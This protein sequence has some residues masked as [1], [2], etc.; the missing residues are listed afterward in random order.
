MVVPGEG[1]FGSRIGFGRDTEAL[2]GVLADYAPY[3][4]NTERL[5]DKLAALKPQRLAIMHGSSFDG[6]G[7][8]AL[9]DLAVAFR[10]TFGRA[11]AAVGD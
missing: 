3:T 7:A 1:S 5:F 10:E 9:R 4:H 2:S 8:R 11:P 6:D